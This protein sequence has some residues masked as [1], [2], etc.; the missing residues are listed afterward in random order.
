MEGMLSPEMKEEITG[1]V[2]IRGFKISK[3]GTVQVVW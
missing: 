1:N 3:I 2:E